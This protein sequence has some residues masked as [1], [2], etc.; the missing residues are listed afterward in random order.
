MTGMIKINESLRDRLWFHFWYAQIHDQ[1][2]I[3]RETL[4]AIQL[5]PMQVS[6][7]EG[8]TF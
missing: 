7:F 8:R 2:V 5:S 4:G 6:R 1:R 3:D